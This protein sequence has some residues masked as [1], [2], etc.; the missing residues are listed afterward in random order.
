RNRQSIK[1]LFIFNDT[2]LTSSSSDASLFHL[3]SE[4]RI[5]LLHNGRTTT[6]YKQGCTYYIGTLNGLY[7]V[8]EKG[9]EVFLGNENPLFKSRISSF[10]EDA[11]G[12]LWIATYDA[13]IIGYRNGEIIANIT[14]HNGNMSSD[15]CRCIFISGN[16]LWAGTEKGLNKIDITPGHYTTTEK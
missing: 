16:T 8:T 5:C 10:A 3:P 9:K 11:L 15:I 7:A 1:T 13:G 2:L 6:A 14:Q 4:R 12:T